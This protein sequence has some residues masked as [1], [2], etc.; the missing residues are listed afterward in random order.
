MTVHDIHMN[1]VTAAFLSAGDDLNTLAPMLVNKLRR[2]LATNIRVGADSVELYDLTPQPMPSLY[3]GGQLALFG[4]YRGS[5]QTKL[6]LTAEIAGEESSI[7]LDVEFPKLDLSAPEIAR[8]WAWHQIQDLMRDIHEN[9]ESSVT[10]D[11]IVALGTAYSITSPY[12]SF[13]AL[14]NEEMYRERGIARRNKQRIADERAAQAARR[15]NPQPGR[16]YKSPR[17]SNW[18]GGG[19]LTLGTL[20]IFGLPLLRRR[21]AREGAK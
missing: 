21:T 7:E 12:T 17:S 9:G 5:G 2:P 1:V 4:R 11:R 20:A 10:R 6:T 18:P 14:E 19:S 3:H 8:M 13:I 15:S 16:V